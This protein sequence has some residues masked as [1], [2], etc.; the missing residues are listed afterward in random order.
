[1]LDGFILFIKDWKDFSGKMDRHNYWS[2]ILASLIFFA[3]V[4]WFAEKIDIFKYMPI[5]YCVLFIIPYISATIRR[6]RDVGKGRLSLL[7]FLIPVIGWACLFVE[8]IQDTG[9]YKKRERYIR[10]KN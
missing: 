4:L 6:L 10:L 3:V 8:L 9:S 7:L 2:A 1:M 5:V